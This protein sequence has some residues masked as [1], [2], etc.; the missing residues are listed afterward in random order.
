MLV[1]RLDPYTKDQRIFYCPG[2][3][4]VGVSTIVDSP[5]NRVAGNI[6]YYWYCFHLLPSTASPQTQWVDA[7]F[8]RQNW[9][10]Q[11][12]LVSDTWD[13]GCWLVSDWFFKDL[14]ATVHTG[15]RRAMNVGYTDGHVKFLVGQ[16]IADFR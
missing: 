14:Y 13:G 4:A 15:H 12:R 2:A 5:E 9:G 1:G 10:N 8:L 11:V 6:S 3:P 7:Q 16:P